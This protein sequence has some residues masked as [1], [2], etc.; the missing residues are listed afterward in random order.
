MAEKLIITVSAAVVLMALLIFAP[1]EVAVCLAVAFAGGLLISLGVL[2]VLS[3]RR[4]LTNRELLIANAGSASFTR[5]KTLTKLRS[6]AR[7]PLE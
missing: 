2:R 7:D 1:T 6:V 4:E 5:T 3:R